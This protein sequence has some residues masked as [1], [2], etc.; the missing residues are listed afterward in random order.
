MY[1]PYATLD[2]K[3]LPML[4]VHLAFLIRPQVRGSCWLTQILN[5]IHHKKEQLMAM[6]SVWET[7]F[8]EA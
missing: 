4:L 8:S 1:V 2:N 7:S 6:C 3:Q 5:V